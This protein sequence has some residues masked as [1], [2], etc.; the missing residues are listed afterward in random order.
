MTF[1]LFGQ[2]TEEYMQKYLTLTYLPIWWKDTCHSLWGKIVLYRWLSHSLKG[3][4]ILIFLKLRFAF[5]VT[6]YSWARILGVAHW[7]YTTNKRCNRIKTLLKT[8]RCVNGVIMP[9]FLLVS[10]MTPFNF[11]I[12]STRNLVHSLSSSHGIIYTELNDKDT[13]LIWFLIRDSNIIMICF[14]S[15]SYFLVHQTSF[16]QWSWTRRE[17]GNSFP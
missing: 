1:V 7:L 11:T 4:Y 3:L 2:G 9:W 6:S 14:L 5:L 12:A 8:S 15:K 13:K 16:R 10:I 17:I